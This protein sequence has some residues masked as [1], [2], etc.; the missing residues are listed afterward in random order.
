ME[1]NEIEFI[2]N[3]ILLTVV[4]EGEVNTNK[5]VLLPKAEKKRGKLG[6]MTCCDP[7]R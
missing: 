2:L 6:G 5:E 7:K 1:L 3:A 4:N